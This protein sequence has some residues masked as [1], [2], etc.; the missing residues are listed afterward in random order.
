[1]RQYSHVSVS[2]S[3]ML[4]PFLPLWPAASIC[5][6]I[7]GTVLWTGVVMRTAAW[8]AFVQGNEQSDIDVTFSDR[9]CPAQCLRIPARTPGRPGC[10]AAILREQAR[11]RWHAESRKSENSPARCVKNV[12]LSPGGAGMYSEEARAVRR[13]RGTTKAGLPC[14]SYALW[15]GTLCVVHARPGPRGPQRLRVEPPPPRKSGATC[16]CA[17]YAW[18]HSPPPGRCRWPEEPEYRLTTPAGTHS[19]WRRP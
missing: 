7:A 6:A 8:V 15:G 4:A 18:P 2:N 5:R 13:C 9:T 11:L 12:H 19:P 17:A 3:S 16:R 14:R 1:M 10:A